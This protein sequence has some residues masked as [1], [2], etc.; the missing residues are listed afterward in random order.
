MSVDEPHVSCT[1]QKLNRLRAGVL[2]A[3]DGIVSVA[4]LVVGVAG[5]TSDTGAIATAG[6]AALVGGAVSMALGEYV[7]VSSQR[8]SERHMIGLESRELREDPEGELEELTQMLQ[9]R[10]IAEATARQAAREMTEHD[11]LAAHL[12]VE[13][14]IDADDLI[15]PWS[16]AFSSAV[17]FTAG[18]LLPLVAMLAT[19]LDA[20]LAVTFATVL[21]ALALTGTISARIGGG[22]RRRAAVRLVVGGALALALTYLIGRLLG[23]SGMV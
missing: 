2:G 19:G 15:S 11:A 6:T 1:S 14:G 16:A 3:N 20:R 10:G 5:A 8:D 4:S 23:S 18:G 7:S 13:L 9:E 12:E 21:V 17:A 22:D